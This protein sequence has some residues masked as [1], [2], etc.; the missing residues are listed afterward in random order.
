MLFP[1]LQKIEVTNKSVF[2]LLSKTTEYLQP[3]PGENHT[4]C[5]FST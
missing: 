4:M 1:L 3:N 2:D 5:V